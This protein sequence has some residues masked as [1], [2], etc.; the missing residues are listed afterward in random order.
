[1]NKFDEETEMLE[2]ELLEKQAQGQKKFDEE[3][4]GDSN[5]PEYKKAKTQLD[6]QFQQ[7]IDN[8]HKSRNEQQN[9]IQMFKNEIHKQNENMRRS[10]SATRPKSNSK[11]SR[12]VRCRSSYSKKS[13][14]IIANSK[15]QTR[16]ST[17]S[18]KSRYKKSNSSSNNNY[19]IYFPLYVWISKKKGNADSNDYNTNKDDEINKNGNND[20]KLDSII[21]KSTSTLVSKNDGEND[22]L[23]STMGP[24]LL[25][26]AEKPPSEDEDEEASQE[27]EEK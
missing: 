21:D 13:R 23:D 12:A 25:M 15:P 27:S 4:N 24:Q 9:K 6:E 16:Q 20:N 2:R 1:M 19:S 22:D 3:W 11:N 10:N 17:S 14:P 18:V 8:F 26:L 5:S 7:E